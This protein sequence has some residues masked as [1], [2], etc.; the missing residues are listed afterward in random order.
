MSDQAGTATRQQPISLR[1]GSWLGAAVCAAGIAA[2]VTITAVG[3]NILIHQ[4]GFAASGGPYQVVSPVPKGFWILPLA[5]MGM[6]GFAFAQ[7][8][9]A[10]RIKGF[11]L[12][13]ATWCAA[14]L[15]VGLMTLWYGFHPPHTLGLATGWV[16]M[17]AIFTV[18]GVASVVAYPFTK[19]YVEWKTF[20]MTGATRAA[21]ALV[22]A[23]A[24]A[25]GV[26]L[27]MAISAAVLGS[28]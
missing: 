7:A 17:G 14:W 9:F 25:G 5:F 3:S 4:G 2:S 28:V 22:T 11:R 18:V 16:V 10:S 27:G 13:W 24:L 23:A 19:R 8:I 15:V 12:L 1:V 20:E 26:L 6:V 21:Y